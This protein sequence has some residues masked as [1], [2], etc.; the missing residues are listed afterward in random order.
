MAPAPSSTSAFALRRPADEWWGWLAGGAFTLGLFLALA[1]FAE[2]GPHTAPA[3]FDDL[4][5][6]S[7]PFTAPPP[8]PRPLDQQLEE[9]ADL[10]PLAGIEPGAS[11][12]AVHL[13]VVPPEFAALLPEAPLPPRATAQ[14]GRLHTDLKPR[15]D[16]VVDPRHVFQVTEVDQPPRAVVR[17][18]PAIPRKLFGDARVLRVVLLLL[19]D[20]SGRA[21]D[22]RVLESSGNAQVDAL[23]MQSVAEDWQFSPAI[24]RG[25]KVRCLAQ[26]GF[27]FVLPAASKFDAR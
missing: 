2:L 5:Q 15:I 23:A 22:T 20:Q 11:D 25:K 10:P 27:R 21:V 12:S 26:Q 19:I 9:A 3:E 17:A 16:V 13:T 14:I 1:H 8:P 6:V 24:R 7:V 18:A 4:R